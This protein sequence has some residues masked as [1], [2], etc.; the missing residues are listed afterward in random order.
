M[1]QKLF[2]RLK[3]VP[4]SVGSLGVLLPNIVAWPFW[5][6]DFD[7][8]FF[9]LVYQFAFVPLFILF[10]G[11]IHELEKSPRFI[12]ILVLV[13]FFGTGLNFLGWG[14]SSGELLTPDFMTMYLIKSEFIIQALA[15]AGAFLIQGVKL[16]WLNF[17][18][19]AK[20]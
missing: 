13:A 17:S 8:A 3:T 1:I 15:G 19:N 11:S 12:S 6:T 7:I 14:W 10:I 18:T 16:F 2:H 20:V 9:N 4:I 5:F